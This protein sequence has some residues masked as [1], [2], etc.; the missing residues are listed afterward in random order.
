MRRRH[1]VFALL[2]IPAVLAGACALFPGLTVRL[3]QR[4]ELH[5]AGLE[6][7]AIDV[8]GTHVAYLIGGS[9][10]PL[11]VLHGFGADKSNWVRVAKYLTPHYRVVAPDLPG[12]GDS[13][14]DPAAHYM[15]DDQV[16]RVHAFAQAL[17]LGTFHLGGN[18]MGGTIAGVYA[19]RHPG[20]VKSLWLLAPGSVRSAEKSEL[21]ALM[22]HGDN[23]LFVHDAA[24]FTRLLDFVFVEPPSIPGPIV[25]YLAA[26]AVRHRDFNEKI[27][28]EL[29]RDPVVLEDVL[30]TV[31]VPTLVVWG[32]HDRLAHVSGARILGG[33]M[34]RATVVVMPN[35]G[36][37]PMVE[38]P[39]E[40]ARAFIDFLGRA[41]ATGATS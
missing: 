37:V 28:A 11:L 31:N 26:E 18:S 15:I 9:G 21:Q 33:A 1:L 6:Q 14:R 3:A 12:F 25:K 30:R 4:M 23:P 40:S 29:W 24:G 38:K 16:E 10:E 41:P 13:T 35:V 2:A 34:P 20:E 32:D 39:E 7:R 5:A 8:G 19:A 36:H 27:A 22:A 17:G